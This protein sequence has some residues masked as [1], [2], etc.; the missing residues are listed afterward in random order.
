[1]LK[2][3]KQQRDPDRAALREIANIVRSAGNPRAAAR[4]V[5]TVLSTHFGVHAGVA[6][7][8]HER[9]APHEI[10]A[11]RSQKP[12]ASDR[13][14]RAIGQGPHARRAIED[15]K[16]A[17]A[18][19]PAVLLSG[20]GAV[21]TAA[22]AIHAMSA[23]SHGPFVPLDCTGWTDT[24]L[25]RELFGHAAGGARQSSPGCCERARGGTLFLDGIH[26]LPW[27]VQTKLLRLLEHREFVPLGASA[28]M[29][30]DLR[31]IAGTGRNLEQAVAAGAFRADLYFR[32][33]ALTVSLP[34]LHATAHRDAADP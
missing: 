25:E 26:A 22:R 29:P 14:E 4:R 34:P 32:L 20:A 17:A 10:R 1:M 2:V 7:L 18:A 16:E 9:R 24:Q 5:L 27:S 31:V 23:R 12:R 6:D 28:P 11:A 19:R 8:V 33:R 21:E 13:L 3:L 30:A 15:I